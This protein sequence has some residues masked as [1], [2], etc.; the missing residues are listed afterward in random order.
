MSQDYILRNEYEARHNDLM[1]QI[2]ILTD[3]VNALRAIIEKTQNQLAEA[4][5]TTRVLMYLVPILTSVI[6]FLLGIHL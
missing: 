1:K 5:G 3:D 6:G 2:G 4:R